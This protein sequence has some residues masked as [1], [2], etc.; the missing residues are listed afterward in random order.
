MIN[1]VLRYNVTSYKKPFYL[2]TL[3][4]EIQFV[5]W[6]IKTIV[7]KCVWDNDSTNHYKKDLYG[8][9]FFLFFGR[10]LFRPFKK[11]PKK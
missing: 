6:L 9:H 7:I 5:S 8:L 4:I 2:K 3:S 11:F 10:M 1:S